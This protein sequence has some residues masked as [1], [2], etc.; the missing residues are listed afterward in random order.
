MTPTRILF[1][2]RAIAAASLFFLVG[3]RYGEPVWLLDRDIVLIGSVYAF[4]LLCY[5]SF[6]PSNHGSLRSEVFAVVGGIAF[7]SALTLTLLWLYSASNTEV[8]RLLLGYEFGVSSGLLALNRLTLLQPFAMI[9]NVIVLGVTMTPSLTNVRLSAFDGIFSGN[10]NAAFDDSVSY[11]L[12]SRHDLRV[13]NRVILQ[14]PK[15]VPGGGLALIDQHTL[16]VGTGDGEFYVVDAGKDDVVSVLRTPVVAPL[17]R[18]DYLLGAANPSEYFRVTD[19]HLQPS[20]DAR[21]SLLVT[22]HH[23][24]AEEQCITLQLS[25][26]TIDVSD[27]RSVSATWTTRFESEPCLSIDLL[28]PET[29]GKMAFLPPNSLLM[30]VG[31]YLFE[32]HVADVTEFDKSSYGK[33]IELDLDDWE[34]R[35]FSAGHRNPQGLLVTRDAIWSTEHGPHGGDE[36]NLLVRGRDYGWPRSTYGTAY[37][38]KSWPLTVGPAEHS[39]GEEPVVA[40]VPS[41]GVSNLVQMD[42]P[43]FPAWEGNL[44]VGSLAGLGNGYSLYRVVVRG[45]RAVTMERIV[46]GRHVRD[47]V[48]LDT[49][50]LILWDGMQSLQF[51]S[52]A[53][54]AYSSCSGCHPLRWQNHGI[55]PDLM[56]VVGARV[57]RYD[58]Y[59]YSE[60]LSTAGGRWTVSRLDAFLRDPQSVMPGTKMIVEG[61]PDAQRRTEII[62]FLMDSAKAGE[63]PV[64]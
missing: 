50:S 1:A 6:V 18:E 16:L 23:W 38:Q 49:G 22:H 14:E 41:I 58:N 8:S 35:V 64:P 24:H 4:G 54:Q 30:S 12:S 40:W 34:H 26:T 53:T 32:S 59:A 29:G 51:V 3:L 48:K 2:S 42:G 15:S 61:I 31:N 9:I 25:E 11:V 56:G 46:T 7:M 60:A 37:G 45:N 27:L 10:R 17:N 19:I 47:L 55:G 63:L 39:F 33:V 13:A 44:I 5:L 62:Q 36:L 20:T 43:S 57:A 21:R 52:P 28:T